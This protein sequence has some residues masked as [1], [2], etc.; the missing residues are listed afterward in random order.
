MFKSIIGKEKMFLWRHFPFQ[1]VFL[2]KRILVFFKSASKL[3]GPNIDFF[4][5]TVF[6]KINT[7]LGNI[8]HVDMW[9][10]IVWIIQGS[11]AT[12]K[13]NL[14]NDSRQTGVKLGD[15]ENL[16][17]HMKPKRGGNIPCL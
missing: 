16:Q 15:A 11:N 17:M 13:V 6:L 10:M 2:N 3:A 4:F 8:K 7:A 12:N 14:F 5:Y 9:I 1:V